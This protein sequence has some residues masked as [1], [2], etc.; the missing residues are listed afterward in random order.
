[1][2]VSFHSTGQEQRTEVPMVL[3]KLDWMR[4][5]GIWP[6]G[7]RYLWTDAFGVVMWREPA[8]G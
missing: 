3:E 2:I 1:M 8:V 4:R 7:K 6:N 5:Q